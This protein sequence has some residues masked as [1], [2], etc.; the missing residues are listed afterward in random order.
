MR[1]DERLREVI[2]RCVSEHG[3]HVIQVGLR[4]DRGAA[5]LQVFIDSLEPVTIDRCSQVSR[6]LAGALGQEDLLPPNYRLEVSTPGV[7]RPLDYPWQYPKHKGRMVRLAVREG[8]ATRTVEGILAES[9]D[10]GIELAFPDGSRTRFPFSAIAKA[11][12]LTPW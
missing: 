1:V 3:A 2:D 11:T 9:D 4:G 10:E 7:D 6:A 12:I 8:D 5:L